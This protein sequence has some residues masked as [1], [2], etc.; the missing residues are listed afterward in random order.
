MKR[1]MDGRTHEQVVRCDH[2]RRS[3]IVRLLEFKHTT[4]S[5]A[6]KTSTSA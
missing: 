1:E 2:Q 3:D 4:T 5:N 6:T